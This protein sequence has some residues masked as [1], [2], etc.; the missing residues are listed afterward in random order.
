ME[1]SL[2]GLADR[3]ARLD[4]RPAVFDREIRQGLGLWRLREPVPVEEI[5][6]AFRGHPAFVD[7]DS[8]VIVPLHGQESRELTG[9]Y[10]LF[11]PSELSPSVVY[12]EF[13]KE[14]LVR[15]PFEAFDTAYPA[16]RLR[17]WHPDYAPGAS[18]DAD[19]GANGRADATA[20]P[21]AG[22]AASGGEAAA[23][24]TE[25]AS[26]AAGGGDTTPGA[27]GGDG[28]PA[29]LVSDATDA[30]SL[31]DTADVLDALRGFVERER[32]AERRENR[33]RFAR[34]SPEQYCETAGGVPELEPA[35]VDIDEYGQQSI[36]LR[37]PEAAVESPVD[38][39]DQFG[40]YPG[41]EVVVDAL[42]DRSGFPIEA[43]LL[44]V[45][46]RRLSLGVYWDRN[47]DGS[48]N[49]AAFEPD[50]DARYALGELLNPV[51]FDREQEAI[52]LVADDPRKRDLL[53]GEADR[54]SERFP[55]VSPDRSRLND[56][57]Y[58]AA[59]RALA[60]DDV[61]CV[62]GPPGTGKTR[63]LIEVVK[64]ACR[65]G[66]RVL[67]SAHSNQAVDN[68]LVG[69]STPDEPDE[70]SLH[71]AV[72]NGELTV[73]RVGDNSTNE[74]VNE[75][76]VDQDRYQS[77]VVCATMSGADA[78]SANL[79]DLAVVDEA[80]QAT[81]T[82][83]MIPFS[84]AERTVLAGDHKQLPPY[85]STERSETEAIEISL[86]E[87]LLARYGERVVT[88]LGIQ[89]RMNEAIAAFPNEAFY[90]GALDHGARNRVWSLSTFPPLE[91]YD[92]EGEERE[93]PGSS[94]YNER[95][96]A[97]VL[98]ELERLFAKDVAPE[99]VGVITPYAGQASKLR[100]KLATLPGDD[101]ADRL[102]VDTV[103]SFQGSEREVIVVSFVRS[104]PQGWSGFLEFPTEGPR[105]LNV[106]L[107]R[108]R[109]RC[110]LVGNFDTLRTRAP[111]LDAD[112]S[113]ADVY[114][115]LY[116][117]LREVDAFSPPP[118]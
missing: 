60:T 34:L 106:A 66:Q 110:V 43:E 85:H 41:S 79:F 42:D 8:N 61:C 4:Q 107:T 53:T 111:D 5:V 76:Y 108:A 102:L 26:G 90:G 65:D 80:T 78:F 35:G 62:H 29:Q 48:P 47:R 32:E 86:F 52:E 56:D 109:K 24:A 112:E 70:N 23:S 88:T 103:D 7:D 22:T 19:A 59:E 93:T 33:E 25:V 72:V 97:V 114:Q 54:S 20:G 38:L 39:P 10:V 113:A 18:A 2:D 58:R 94:I 45:D 91:A 81:T 31:A 95:E 74:I 82:A 50:A 9:E 21:V 28:L 15:V 118:G 117:H 11:A 69:D 36:N 92:V 49:E 116:D 27:G 75:W 71:H 84:R 51:P 55:D 44:E 13:S 105:R 46:G 99:D 14:G 77:D 115:H 6:A 12:Y 68:L 89:Y 16:W 98:A 63:T 64:T 83:S 73:A 100:G 17:F 3:F 1:A 40:V 30:T 101:L 57:Q 87:H 96:I 67:V 104:N 37:V